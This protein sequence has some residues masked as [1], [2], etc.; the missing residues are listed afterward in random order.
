MEKENNVG[1]QVIFKYLVTD[2]SSNSDF[3]EEIKKL[4][5]EGAIISNQL[6]YVVW[7]NK[8]K[9]VKNKIEIYKGDMKLI[10]MNVVEVS[11]TK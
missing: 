4:A 1:E 2:F 10:V 9:Y 11:K 5:Y 3:H 6:G 8:H 7:Q